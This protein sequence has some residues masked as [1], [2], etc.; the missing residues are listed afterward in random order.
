ML[1]VV[2]LRVQ[3]AFGQWLYRPGCATPSPSLDWCLDLIATQQDLRYR[4]SLVG[5]I[6]SIRS[7]SGSL[8]KSMLIFG[9]LV[10]TSDSHFLLCFLSFLVAQQ[11]ISRPSL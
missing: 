4:D 5:L 2:V 8:Y 10:L 7:A 9:L 6:K 11:I 3:C 1:E